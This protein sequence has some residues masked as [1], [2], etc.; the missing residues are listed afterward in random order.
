M[1]EAL[2]MSTEHEP[3]YFSERECG[4][5]CGNLMPNA[6]ANGGRFPRKFLYGHKPAEPL[7][8]SKNP[9]GVKAHVGPE[10]V[11]EY[12]NAQIEDMKTQGKA[13]KSEAEILLAKAKD[14]MAAAKEIDD[15]V[16]EAIGLRRMNEAYFQ[17]MF[18][19]KKPDERAA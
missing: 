1:R 11:I 10:K 18:G 15:K 2:Q 6:W 9:K 13:L 12:L 4:C 3:G 5:G 8:I 14:K 17:K 19:S 7:K 16:T